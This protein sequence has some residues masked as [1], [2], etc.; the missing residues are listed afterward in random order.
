MVV[1]K[2][3]IRIGHSPDA[4]DAFMIYGIAK[5]KVDTHGLTISHVVEEIQLLN[6][7]A[8]RGELEVTAVSAYAFFSDHESIFSYDLWGQHR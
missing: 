5:G 1:V 2:G 3:R 7:R 6:E 4:D 8:M